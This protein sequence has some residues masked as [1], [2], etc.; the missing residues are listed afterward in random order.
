MGDALSKS[1][2]IRSS[3]VGDIGILANAVPVGISGFGGMG[4][5]ADSTDRTSDGEVT[6]L[7]R[8]VLVV[9]LAG[10]GGAGGW[11]ARVICS[12]GRPTARAS[13]SGKPSDS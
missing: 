11:I 8:I 3:E 5:T 9:I 10:G 12:L 6:C 2:T 13:D 7:G 4:V 1:I